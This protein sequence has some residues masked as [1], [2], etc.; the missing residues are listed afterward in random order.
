MRQQ[1]DEGYTKPRCLKSLSLALESYGSHWQ[2]PTEGTTTTGCG[3]LVC[4]PERIR[5]SVVNGGR[6][7][8]FTVSES[9]IRRSSHATTRPLPSDV[10]V[11]G[12]RS[13]G[14][15]RQLPRLFADAAS[16][17][18]TLQYTIRF[19]HLP[20]SHIYLNNHPKGLSQHFH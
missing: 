6:R 16:A 7:P 9:P 10:T 20:F 18:S 4:V 14:R 5:S 3:R 2:L 11:A 8:K 15:F 1:S 12:R 13:A 19:S 17:L